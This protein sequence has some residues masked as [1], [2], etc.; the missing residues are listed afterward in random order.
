[1][2]YNPSIG[3]EINGIKNVSVYDSN[4]SCYKVVKASPQKVDEYINKRKKA[5]DKDNTKAYACI[6]GLPALGALLGFLPIVKKYIGPREKYAGVLGGAVLGS[7]I[8]VLEHESIIQDYKT[9]KK[10]DQQ[11]IQENS[12]QSKQ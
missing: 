10:V 1:M 3:P 8:G 12:T 6:F 7:L 5:I 9:P 2:L 11:F 4:E